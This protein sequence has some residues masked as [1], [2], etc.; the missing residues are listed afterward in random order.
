MQRVRMSRRSP[1]LGFG[2]LW[3]CLLCL[4]ALLLPVAARAEGKPNLGLSVTSPKSILFGAKATVTMEASNPTGEPY[5]YNLS[6]RAVLPEGVA[7][8]PGSS[9]LG[10]GGAAPTPTILENQPK[11]KE[12]TLI[13]SNVGDLSPASHSTLSFEV[14]P[15]Q[16]TYLVASEFTV[17]AEAFIAEAPRYLP[18]FKSGG[19]P[20]GPES[21]S[22]TGYAKGST[23]TAISALEIKQEEG[24]P[25]G[26]I[27]RG[28]H[29]HQTVYKVTVT[30]NK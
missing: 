4:L 24:S 18:K 29:D 22:F 11:T 27:L 15:S 9:K 14:T 2:L 1:L 16:V 3:G 5:G 7:Y 21:T 6:Y 20:K 13:W 23:K 25:E 28:V 19:E 10:S 12:T 26:E 30:N 17:P 8:V